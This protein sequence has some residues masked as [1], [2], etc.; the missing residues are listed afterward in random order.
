ME[1]DDCLETSPVGMSIGLSTL[2][3]G[4]DYQRLFKRVDRAM[5]RA[6]QEGK[7]RYVVD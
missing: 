4:D 6:K 3:A 5:Y 7:H 2:Y 1:I